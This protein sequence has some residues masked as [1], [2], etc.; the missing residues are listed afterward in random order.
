MK[1]HRPLLLPLLATALAGCLEV[2]QHPAWHDGQYDGKTDALPHQAW[3]H[4]DRMAWNAAITDRTLLQN[5]Y[6]RTEPPPTL[7]KKAER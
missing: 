5:E 1:A 2:G 6:R 3:F 7:P 4:G